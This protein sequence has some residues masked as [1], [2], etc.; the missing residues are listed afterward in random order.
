MGGDW[1]PAR[2]GPASTR[3]AAASAPPA[4]TTC[5]P[6]HVLPEI[7][8]ARRLPRLDWLDLNSTYTYEIVHRNLL[9]D[10][11][12][13]PA[14]PFF[15]VESTYE[16]E[17]NATELQI[18]RQAYWSVLCGGNGHCMGNHPIWLFGDGWEDALDLPARWRWHAGVT[19]SAAC[20]GPTSSRIS[21]TRVVTAGSARRG[22]SIAL[23][24]AATPDRRLAVAYLPARRAITIEPARL[25]GPQVASVGSS[26]RRGAGCR[27]HAG[28]GGPGDVTPPFA[29]DAALLLASA[30]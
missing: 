19:F 25:A 6:A 1:H 28:R 16:G 13:N 29:E 3:M 30:D 2:P 15:L 5:S 4:S 26:R 20:P 17:H 14:W 10:W 8:A 27:R 18:R 21:T 24:A 9:D 12:R 7:L 11:K 22:A 23:T